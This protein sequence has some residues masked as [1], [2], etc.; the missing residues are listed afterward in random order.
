M[1]ER[2]S[3]P[4]LIS[5]SVASAVHGAFR[6][7]LNTD[8]VVDL[9]VDRAGLL[10]EA[11]TGSFYV[12][13][14]S[15]LTA[16]VDRSHFNL[17]HLETMFRVDIFISRGRPFDQSQFGRRVAV[18]LTPDAGHTVFVASPEDVILAKLEWYGAGGQ[19][20]DRQ[21]SDILSVLAVQSD[22][23]DLAYLRTWAEALGVSPLL[24]RAL[25]DS[26]S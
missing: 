5:G 25:A 14:E 13:V 2:L 1:L 4:Y 21:W 23:L 22:R 6:S 26:R 3:V 18:S 11:L 19:V 9:P 24:D 20:S 16:I 10:A 7:T 12:D 17:I 8:L 15:I